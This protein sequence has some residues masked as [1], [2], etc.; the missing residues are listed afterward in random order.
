MSEIKEKAARYRNLM[1]DETFQELLNETR[2]KLV[3][4]FLTPSA[5]IDTINEAHTI[6][7][8][9]NEIENTLNAALDAEAVYDKHNS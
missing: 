6:V 4:V 8:A 9:L 1:R 5:S 2:E 3:D 7:R